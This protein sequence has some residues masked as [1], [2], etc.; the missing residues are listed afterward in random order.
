MQFIGEGSCTSKS[1]TAIDTGDKTIDDCKEECRKDSSCIA[2]H[3][4]DEGVSGVGR[5]KC[6]KLSGTSENFRLDFTTSGQLCY[7]KKGNLDRNI[8]VYLDIVILC[9]N[10]FEIGYN[11]FYQLLQ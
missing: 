10:V 8:A 11:Y 5:W 6:R 9:I 4:S 7:A 1:L 2:I 3:V